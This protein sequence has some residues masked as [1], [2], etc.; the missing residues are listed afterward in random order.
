M[1]EETKAHHPRRDHGRPDLRLPFFDYTSLGPYFL[2][3]CTDGRVSLFGRIVDG[4]M[5]LNSVGQI[6]YDEWLRSAELRKELMLDAF[7]IM[8]N[9]LHAIAGIADSGERANC[10]LH[11]PDPGRSPRPRRGLASFIAGYKA[12]TTKLINEQRGSPGQRI[13]QPNYYERVIRDERELDRFRRY[14]VSNA[15]RWVQDREN[16]DHIA[17]E[18]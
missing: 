10:R 17:Y 14:I 1:N 18:R 12:Y 2:T 15:A 6:V 16:P 8:P 3:L 5:I 4:E 13:W 9:H 11:L 7:V